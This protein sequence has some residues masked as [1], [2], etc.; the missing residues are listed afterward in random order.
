MPHIFNDKEIMLEFKQTNNDISGFTT[1]SG[2]QVPNI[3]EQGMMNLSS[4]PTAPPPCW[5]GSI[6]ERDLK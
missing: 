2:N 5:A 6:T 3:S 4:S 1:I